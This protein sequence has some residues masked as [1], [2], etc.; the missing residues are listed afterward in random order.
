[1]QDLIQKG[2][3]KY[4]EKDKGVM[5]VDI[6]PFPS[7]VEI[8]M[9][10]TDQ[11]KKGKNPRVLLVELEKLHKERLEKM[12]KE[13]KGKRVQKEPS[14]S[15]ICFRCGSEKEK[16]KAIVIYGIQQIGK[17][18]GLRFNTMGSGD[19]QIFDNDCLFYDGTDPGIFG[20]AENYGKDDAPFLF[21]GAPVHPCLVGARNVRTMLNQHKGS[22]PYGNP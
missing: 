19:L 6:D 12:A 8:N 14:E 16:T 17:D 1:M 3:L 5:A 11:K 20:P 21:Q 13:A 7:M 9:V 18:V 15:F 2:M 4:A 22:K 10:A